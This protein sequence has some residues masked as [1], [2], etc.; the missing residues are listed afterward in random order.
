MFYTRRTILQIVA[1]VYTVRITIDG[2]QRLVVVC[3]DFF[4]SGD[5]GWEQFNVDCAWRITDADA[6]RS[7]SLHFTE[8]SDFHFLLSAGAGAN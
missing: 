8:C 7:S 2:W 6:A 5:S 3:D 1:S 4:A